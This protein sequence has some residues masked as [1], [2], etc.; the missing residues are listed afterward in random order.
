M[1]LRD[2]LVCVILTHMTNRTD[3]H[4]E[5]RARNREKL[6][7]YYRE[8]R[9]AN[10]ER[11]NAYLREYRQR[12]LETVREN[13]RRYQTKPRS[14]SIQAERQRIRREKKRDELNAKACA[15]AKMR[16]DSDENYRIKCQLRSRLYSALRGNSKV[17][18]AVRLLGCSIEEFRLYLES[19]FQPGWGW[20][21]RHE[22]HID[23]IKP[24]CAFDL[25]D[26]AQLADACHYTNLRPLGAHENRSKGGKFQ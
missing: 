26:P 6:A 25:T 23:H 18:S 19:Q 24:L 8:Y 11:I 5:W 4:R 3:Y 7:D 20:N 16:Y 12:N 1:L 10:K 13:E 15:Y 22:W 9:S 2:V 21:N 14:K 17:G